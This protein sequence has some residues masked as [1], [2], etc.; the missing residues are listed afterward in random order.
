MKKRLLS[1]P[2]CLSLA[3]CLILTG[4]G[5]GSAVKADNLMENV[6]ADTVETN[7]DL[8]GENG[9]VVT[10][11]GVRLFQ[12]SLEADK[13]IL[14]SP[15]SVICALAMTANGA[16]GETL[17]QM[18]TVLGLPVPDLNAYL[19]T[20]LNA[21]PTGDKYKLSAANS[22]WFKDDG[23]FTVSQSFLQ[24]NA[25]WYGAGI[26]K[27]PFDS[28]TRDDINLW[29][30]DHTDE[31]IEHILDEIPADAVMY[32]VNALAFDAEWETIYEADEVRDGKF[33][34]EDGSA[35]DVEM[36]YSLEHKY[37]D[38]SSAAGFIKYY[39]DRKYAFAALLPDKGTSV[40][41][42][43]A[44]LSGAKL[45]KLLSNPVDVPVDTAIPKF[46]TEYSTEMGTV[47]RAMG[48]TDAFS[49]DAQFSG[50]GTSTKG[51]LFISRVLHK[52]FI[53]LDEKGTKAG[54]ASAVEMLTESAQELPQNLKTVHLDRPFIYLLIDCEANL[55]VFMGMVMDV[56][57]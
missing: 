23:S 36:M 10:D 55:P 5:S 3:M 41:D 34:T 50:I 19:H 26:F 14:V 35:R 40:A 15:L 12:Q 39:A 30:R 42:Y 38:D 54:A 43:A 2:L 22:I 27:A 16:R 31:M 56:G 4:C 9:A 51:N 1:S 6:K 13:N 46:T 47:L 20:Y 32:L 8:T 29:V 11:F 48:M 49:T 53:S 44:T 24:T 57:K 37:I 52:T 28:S 25:D 18:E 33:T 17:S 7:A 21:L 45:S